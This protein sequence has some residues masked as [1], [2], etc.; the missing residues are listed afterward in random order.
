MFIHWN[1][2]LRDI[3]RSHISR[4]I[5]ETVKEAYTRAE[6]ESMTELQHMRSELCQHHGLTTVRWHYLTFCQLRFG[7]R[8]ESS[9]IP[10]YETWLVLLMGC[11]R[12]VQWW[13][14]NKSWI[15]D[16]FSHLHSLHDLYAATAATFLMKIT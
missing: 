2:N 11:L 6:R 10:I 13:S 12:W 15:Q 9:R 16:I 7:G 1:R 14:H 4:W 8:Q 5:M 3:M